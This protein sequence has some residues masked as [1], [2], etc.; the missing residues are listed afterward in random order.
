MLFCIAFTINGN[1]QK[2]KIDQSWMSYTEVSDAGFDAESVPSI[3]ELYDQSGLS[4]LMI[5]SEGHILMEYGNNTRR[6]M[7][8]SIRKSF[9][10]ALFGI[11]ID[12]GIIDP[13]L[14][15]EELGIDDKGR[16]TET[17]KKATIIDLLSARS[18]VYLP[19][20]YSPQ[21][22]EDNLPSRGSHMPGDHWYYN[23]WDFNTLCTIFEKITGTG[24]YE[25]FMNEL[26]IPLGMEDFRIF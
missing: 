23:N 25:A 2:V 24:I 8:H 15:L 22:M 21:S 9:L 18:G 7:A 16:L 11:Y 4:G 10:S 6:F 5:I 13:G 3:R 12:R 17:E 19:S 1:S 14:S 26:A 20:A